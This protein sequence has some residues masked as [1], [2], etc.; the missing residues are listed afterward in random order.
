[1]RKICEKTEFVK[2][3]T[4]TGH[5]KE[6]DL[7]IEWSVYRHPLAI[8]K[9]EM[10]SIGSDLAVIASLFVAYAVFAKAMKLL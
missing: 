3:M 2:V 1:M 6:V 7:C 5:V 4:S 10:L 9:A 8:T